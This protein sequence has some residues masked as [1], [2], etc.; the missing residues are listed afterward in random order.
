MIGCWFGPRI[1]QALLRQ[2]PVASIP[3]WFPVV[4]RKIT[5]AEEPFA[6]STIPPPPPVEGDY[7]AICATVRQSA[8]GRWF[9][10]E[11]AR[12]NRNADTGVV[13]AA[14][15]RL[16][17][18]VQG[19]RDREA[20]HSMRGDLLEMARTIAVTRA[21]VAESQAEPRTEDQPAE[22]QPPAGGDV[23]A[24]AERIQD[25]AW[26]M[27]ERGLD[28]RT[29]EQIETLATTILSAS[30]LRDPNDHRTRKLGEVLQYL[31]RRIDQML[32]ACAHEAPSYEQPSCAAASYEP[33]TTT[34]ERAA[35]EA[36]PAHA[37]NGYGNGHD[38]GHAN[39][40]DAAGVDA[41]VDEPPVVEAIAEP[42]APET[43][44]EPEPA[45]R[46]QPEA[47]V[48]VV[49]PP[50][51]EAPAANT[52]LAPVVLEP[53]SAA[54][55]EPLAAAEPEITEPVTVEAEMNVEAPAAEPPALPVAPAELASAPL[56][57]EAV[58]PLPD[59]EP[60]VAA[61]ALPAAELLP[62]ASLDLPAAPPEPA[63]AEPIVARADT[64]APAAVVARAPIR[65]Q[66]RPAASDL[67]AALMAMSDE[68]RI[69]L[70]T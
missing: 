65:P 47:L 52:A 63:T 24:M 35:P 20:Y 11:Y 3:Y 61:I 2:V 9:L 1:V 17:T 39:G 44:A 62:P 29:C 37:G 58:A 6:L 68:E 16:E 23:F 26:T 4:W 28:P 60:S 36:E 41:L 55:P 43:E 30:A 70:F 49:E 22:R 42:A 10:D 21:E 50:A 7:D 45:E 59:P 64:V 66:L 27:R 33:A 5:M 48:V 56:Q 8:R 40:H 46:E 19:S 31:E 34:D 57:S 54:A 32:E 38:H 69:A 67:L 25:V 18:V 51:Y 53:P 14:I 13:L 15:E 12:R